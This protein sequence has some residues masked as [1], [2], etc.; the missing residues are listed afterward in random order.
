MLMLDLG[1]GLGGA[2]LAMKKRGWNV[3]T[4]DIDP[5]FG[6]DVVADMLTWSWRGER[7]DFV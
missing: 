4:M 7:P 2:S 3:V 5:R 1:S 6:T